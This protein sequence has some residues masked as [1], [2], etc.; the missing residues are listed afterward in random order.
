MHSDIISFNYA[1]PSE[2]TRF[3][4]GWLCVF[5]GNQPI[6]FVACLTNEFNNYITAVMWKSKNA[7][8]KIN[9]IDMLIQFEDSLSTLKIWIAVRRP[10]SWYSIDSM[11][12][13]VLLVNLITPCSP[14]KSSKLNQTFLP[15]WDFP[16]TTWWPPDCLE[17]LFLYLFNI[18]NFYFYYV[19]KWFPKCLIKTMQRRLT[20]TSVTFECVCCAV[21]AAAAPLW[22]FIKSALNCLCKRVLQNT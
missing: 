19:C 14:V 6:C 18:H 10:G 1:W 3:A 20:W 17:W 13:L 8:P 9:C 12:C 2:L 11:T 16:W 22:P 7:G 21:H 15:T 4:G 5:K